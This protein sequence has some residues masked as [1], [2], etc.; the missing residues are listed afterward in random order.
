M[1]V[2]VSRPGAQG[3]GVSPRTCRALGRAAG[4]SRQV[5]VRSC[6]SGPRCP[7]RPNAVPLDRIVDLALLVHDEGALGDNRLID[8][9][10]GQDQEMRGGNGFERNLAAAAAERQRVPPI[11]L[12]LA[13]VSANRYV[14]GEHLDNTVVG[15]RKIERDLP[16]H[17]PVEYGERLH[18]HQRR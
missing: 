12:L 3:G 8:P 6:Q 13:A 18:R 17:V 4:V 10:T 16:E 9:G 15:R 1:Q 7:I 2:T 11:Y 14:S 5:C